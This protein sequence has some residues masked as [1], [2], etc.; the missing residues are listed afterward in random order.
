MVDEVAAGDAH[1][2]STDH[3]RVPAVLD[4]WWGGLGGPGLHR[5]LFA[6]TLEDGQL[7]GYRSPSSST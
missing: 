5:V 6:L 2:P 7:P 4:T 3:G 1:H